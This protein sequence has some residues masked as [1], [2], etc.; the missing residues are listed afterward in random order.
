M[1]LKHINLTVVAHVD[2]GKSTLCDAIIE[3]CEGVSIQKDKPSLDNHEIEK[4][5]GV[6]IR[7]H[8]IQLKYK[9]IYINLIDTPGHYDFAQYVHVGINSSDITL[10]VIDVTKGIQPQTLAYMNLCIERK[11]KTIIVLNKIDIDFINIL[12]VEEI[13]KNYFKNDNIVK[14]SAFKRINIDILLEK[15]YYNS[16]PETNYITNFNSGMYILDCISNLTGYTKVLIQLNKMNIAVNQSVIFKNKKYKINKIYTKNFYGYQEIKNVD[17]DI[18]YININININILSNLIG[19]LITDNNIIKIC[20]NK[21]HTSYT[22]IISPNK[23][24]DKLKYA[25]DKIALSDPGVEV[26]KRFSQL[27]GNVFVCSFLGE[28]HQEVFLERLLIE[29]N[30]EFSTCYIGP[31]YR[32][33]QTNEYV[34]L[35]YKNKLLSINFRK[36]LQSI[37]T[38]FVKLDIIFKQE[39]YNKVFTLLSEENYNTIIKNEL[40]LDQFIMTVKIPFTLLLLNFCSQL[41][42]ITNGYA[43]F[44]INDIENIEKTL[45]IIEFYINNELV[46]EFSTIE[47]GSLAEK[48]ALANLERLKISLERQQFLLKI[49]VKINRKNFKSY[50]IKPYR[51]DV[52]AKLYGGDSTRRKKLLNKQ[53][54][55]KSKMSKNANISNIKQNIIKTIINSSIVKREFHK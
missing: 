24:D 7:N 4:T 45:S 36:Y 12:N 54:I 42:S 9:N 29:T 15:I 28:F 48:V 34:I 39:Y 41:K 49:I 55:G 20:T 50:T 33:K 35:D 51:K 25:I 16:Q 11:I 53:K 47:L 10:L 30:I 18:C 5:R 26:N 19:C 44:I 17:N 8:F 2:H 40:I 13:V 23:N 46:E 31:P 27:Y 43:D 6:T 37:L 32:F 1:K 38:P 21:M 22:G 14:V 3:N 52:T